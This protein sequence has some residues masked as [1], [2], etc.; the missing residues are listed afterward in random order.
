MEHSTVTRIEFYCGIGE[1]AWNEQPV[2]PGPFACIAPVYGQRTENRVRVPPDTAVIQDSGAFSD[3]GKSR[4]PFVL[5][6]LRQIRHAR[7]YGYA[8]QVSHVASYDSLIKGKWQGV[9]RAS[10]DNRME[11]R[12]EQAISETVAAARWLADHRFWWPGIGLVLSAQGYTPMQYQ[13]CVKAILP[14]LNTERDILGLG[15]WVGI[16]VRPKQLMPPFINTIQLI[17][18]DIARAG[19][20]QVHIW[21]V[22]YPH[23]LAHLASLCNEYGVQLSTDS[24]GPQVRVAFGEWGYGDWRDNSYQVAPPRRR[25]IDRIRHVEETRRWLSNFNIDRYIG[26]PIQLQL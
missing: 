23:A 22:I 17:F 18:P 3:G 1:T 13:Y 11:T 6:A 4:L 16:G 5:A 8:S 10:E 14:L 2:T 12:A 19:V 7:K 24:I 20:R 21:G 26:K 25:G 9:I 15:G